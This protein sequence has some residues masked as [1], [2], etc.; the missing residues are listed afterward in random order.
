VVGT[1]NSS[2]RADAMEASRCSYS[3]VLSLPPVNSIHQVIE[4]F[5]RTSDHG[6]WNR[7]GTQGDQFELIF[8]RGRWRKAFF[9]NELVPQIPDVTPDRRYYEASTRP[10]VLRILIRPSPKGIRL[11]L[12]HTVFFHEP[13]HLDAVRQAWADYTLK[14]VDS[15]RKYMGEIYELP[16]VPLLEDHAGGKG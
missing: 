14:E 3:R 6:V 15:M 4:A 2:E 9:G 5:L 8:R 13:V 11:T 7:E 10:A 16:D 1:S 12:N